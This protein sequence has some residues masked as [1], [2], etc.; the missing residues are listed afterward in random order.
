MDKV[1]EKAKQMLDHAGIEING[2]RPY[3]IQVHNDKLFKRVFSQGDLGLGESYMDGWWDV[4]QLDEF[5]YRVIA[6]KLQQVMKR[7]WVTMF[8]LARA[9]IF[10]LQK[11]KRAFEVGQKHYDVG[12]DLY[13]AMLDKRMTYTG[14]LWEHTDNLDDAQ[15]AKLDLVCRKLDLKPGQRVLDI[16]C[17][18]GSFAGYAAE[19]YGVSVVGVTVSKEQVTLGNEMYQHL[20][21]ELRLQDYRDVDEKFDHIVSLG[22][23][24]HVGR[25]NY[26]TYMKVVDR[27]LEEEGRFV[28]Q[29]IGHN[30]SLKAASPWT[31][32]Y[33]FPNSMLPSIRLL[34]TSAEKLFTMED[35]ENIG[36]NYDPTLMAWFRNFDSSWDTLKH[37]YS[38]RFYRM[39]KYYLLTSAG[40]F[41]ARRIQL[42]QILFT[43]TGLPGGY[44]RV[45]RQR[46]TQQE[47]PAVDGKH[48]TSVADMKPATGNGLKKIRH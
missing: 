3:D 14:A 19:K 41:R 26:R 4:E 23:I 29:T 22:M 1:T 35:W 8:E 27:C 5:F 25:K 32:R 10:N 38:D 7:D 12:N 48:D 20:P 34:G 36:A 9:Q 6:A 17:G 15:E 21:V 44:K 16:G 33:I 30:Q 13:R 39:W 42:W 46:V 47:K 11:A 37:N 40:S 45:S 18:W 24:E 43:K 28:L 31:E 2:S